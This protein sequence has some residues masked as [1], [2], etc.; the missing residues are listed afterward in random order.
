MEETARAAMVPAEMGW[1][2]IGNW[3]AL[4]DARAVSGDAKGNICARAQPILLDC[5]N[6]MV[7]SDGPRVSVVGLEDVIVVVHGNEVLVTTA[8]R[9]RRRS[10][11]S[12]GREPVTDERAASHP[13]WSKS[14]GAS[15]ALPAPFATPD[16]QAH[17]RNLVRAAARAAALLVKYLFTSEKLSVQVHPSGQRNR[18]GKEECWLVIDAEPGASSASGSTS[19]SAAGGDARRRA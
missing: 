15:S 6:V 9:R 16:R 18:Q 5:R 14:R 19:R 10:A 12:R 8:R 17:R 11:S 2:D 1:S 4:R 7:D 3:Q 13:R